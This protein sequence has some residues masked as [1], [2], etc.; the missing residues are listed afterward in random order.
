MCSKQSNVNLGKGEIK[1]LVSNCRARE[2]SPD[3]MKINDPYIFFCTTSAVLSM[4]TKIRARGP[5]LESPENFSGPKTIRKTAT[6]LFCKAGLFICCRGDKNKN[7]CKVS[8]L[9]TP[10]F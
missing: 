1:R 5:F 2:F 9:K 4:A 8:C 7:D 10:S 6:C 3:K